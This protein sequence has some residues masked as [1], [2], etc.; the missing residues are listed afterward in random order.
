[1]AEKMATPTKH[2]NALYTRLF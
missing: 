2:R 1:V